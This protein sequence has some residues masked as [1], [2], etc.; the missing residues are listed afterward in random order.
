MSGQQGI[1]SR[2]RTRARARARARW[3]AHAGNRKQSRMPME[4]RGIRRGDERSAAAK[5]KGRG[6][7]GG[8]T[9]DRGRPKQSGEVDRGMA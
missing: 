5:M 2:T 9:L 8:K 7:Q 4:G 1:R 6:C 3:R